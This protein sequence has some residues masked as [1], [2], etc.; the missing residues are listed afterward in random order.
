MILMCSKLCPLCIMSLGDLPRN[1][2]EYCKYHQKD[3]PVVFKF[4]KA[5]KQ[6][7]NNKR[8]RKLFT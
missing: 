8:N 1:Q 2:S 5:I 7:V 6:S 4:E 3:L